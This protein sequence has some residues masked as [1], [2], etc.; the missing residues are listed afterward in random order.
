MTFPL[1]S[2]AQAYPHLAILSFI[3]EASLSFKS[4][5]PS[6]SRASLLSFSPANPTEM[7]GLQG[8]AQVGSGPV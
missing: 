4:K 1:I 2:G 3:R 5:L 8:N 7:C 6:F